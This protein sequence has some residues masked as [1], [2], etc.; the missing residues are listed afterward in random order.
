MVKLIQASVALAAA[1]TLPTCNNV[2]VGTVDRQHEPT[3]RLALRTWT[4][5]NLLSLVA[6]HILRD[7]AGNNV[8]IFDGGLD[9]DWITHF[10]EDVY[11]VDVEQWQA[12][13]TAVT[14]RAAVLAGVAEVFSVGYAGRSGLYVSNTV[15][16]T[17]NLSTFYKWYRTTAA[18]QSALPKFADTPAVAPDGTDYSSC[19]A[20]WC[21]NSY[22]WVPEPCKADPSE[23]VEVMMITTDYDQSYFEQLVHNSNSNGGGMKVALKYYGDW[24]YSLIAENAANG[25]PQLFYG[26]EPADFIQQANATRV[27]FEDYIPGCADRM[28]REATGDLNCDYPQ[29]ALSRIVNMKHAKEWAHAW[30]F[31]KHWAVSND[32]MDSM[33]AQTVLGGG[34]KSVEE[35]ACDVVQA[36]EADGKLAA[37][38]CVFKPTANPQAGDIVFSQSTMQC[39]PKSA[40]ASVPL[41][42]E[43][44]GEPQT[45][46]DREQTVIRFALTDR[47]SQQ[48]ATHVGMLVVKEFL[49]HAATAVS[50]AG[51]TYEQILANDVVDV[52]LE[53]WHVDEGSPQYDAVAPHTM[54]INSL[55]Y[56]GRAGLFA[57]KAAAEADDGMPLYYRY[58][59]DRAHVSNF[60]TALP[61]GLQFPAQGACTA[62]WCTDSNTYVP[63]ACEGGGA[64]CAH[65]AMI[66]SDLDTGYLEALVETY[67]LK[68]K[69][70]YYGE[71]G[72]EAALD[73]W[74]TTNAKAL[75]YGVTPDPHIA[76][77]GASRVSFRDFFDGCDDTHDGTTTTSSLKCDFTS[78]DLKTILRAGL[79]EIAPEAAFVLREMRLTPAHMDSLLQKYVLSSSANVQQD[80]ACAW[81]AENKATLKEWAADCVTHPIDDPEEGDEV[82]RASEL[83]CVEVSCGP[84]QYVDQGECRRCSPGQFP[85]RVAG[86]WQCGIA[87][88]GTFADGYMDEPERCP[89]GSVSSMGQ[90]S[91]DPCRPGSFSAAEG[92]AAQC[93]RCPIGTYASALNS[94]Q[95]TPCPAEIPATLESGSTGEDQCGCPAGSFLHL[96]EE[97]CVECYEGYICPFG[98]AEVASMNATVVTPSRVPLL[99]QPG[100][101]ATVAEPMVAYLCTDYVGCGAG[102][103]EEVDCSDDNF[104]TFKTDQRCGRPIGVCTDQLRDASAPAC[105]ICLE[106]YFRDSSGRCTE[107]G[108]ASAGPFILTLMV[109]AGIVPV[110]YKT[111]SSSAGAEATALLA[112]GM[113]FGML[114][115]MMQVVASAQDLSIPWSEEVKQV[116][117]VFAVVML[118]V[119]FLKTDCV[120][121]T[122]FQAYFGSWVA[123]YY[124]VGTTLLIW[125]LFKLI[126]KPLITARLLSSTGQVFQALYIT[127]VM[128]AL[129]PLTCFGHPSERATQASVATM[130]SVLC[131]SSEHA[132]MVVLG[133]ASTIF[134]S[135]GFFS[136]CTWANWNAK[137]KSRDVG[138]A[139]FLARF[140][141]LFYRFQAP[142]WYWGSVLQCRSL[143]L[144]F[145][146]LIASDTG[147]LQIVLMTIILALYVALACSAMPWK[148]DVLNAVDISVSVLL[149]C[150]TSLATGI[151]YPS[152]DVYD[153][154]SSGMIVTLGGASLVAFSAVAQAIYM[155]AKRG[156]GAKVA[157]VREAEAMA[158]AKDWSAIASAM[159]TCTHDVMEGLTRQDARLTAMVINLLKDEVTLRTGKPVHTGS[160]QYRISKIVANSGSIQKKAVLQTSSS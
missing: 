147:A 117:A 76:G 90:A 78:Y 87:P 59:A 83:R 159:E 8:E 121:S 113:S 112:T 3:I 110:V 63:Q 142:Y 37:Y 21:T 72:H 40:Y 42:E 74:S 127:F 141:F 69:F 136:L 89:A 47:A 107:C 86:V 68:M 131:G 139:T 1:A 61:S 44:F 102:E 160:K 119:S 125:A 22:S 153:S 6:A 143:L 116:I 77:L 101:H 144:S 23:C 38:D 137:T 80:A 62:A 133:L 7:H 27:D 126:R 150:F 51:E 96:Q 154:L 95:C 26:W 70:A 31:L 16:S 124:V 149:L 17:D 20:D 52:I 94:T 91:C 50:V 114:V 2:R 58:Y 32:E 43:C 56:A 48:L 115:S 79:E 67:G 130:P 9:A 152:S 49:G 109:G 129:R 65:V 148:T 111:T 66:S 85:K 104:K 92:D 10:E 19:F 120:A 84:G 100:Y 108:A 73:A 5:Q 138:G 140:R 128:I 156:T 12:S 151:S 34:S 41:T 55:G 98:A 36:W 93:A 106:G 4:S 29:Y 135:G 158:L 64:A 60:E 25:T 157:S 53:A 14:V 118:D 134:V 35:V 46:V 122:R 81:A 18:L 57:T 123:P 82:F 146:P 54:S 11:D 75:F 97:R 105:G 28:T 45:S 145:V 24:A 103:T 99:V 30:Y 88:A 71:A 39:A 13:P 132:N 33:L 155:L 15:V